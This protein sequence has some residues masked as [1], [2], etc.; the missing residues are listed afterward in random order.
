MFICNY[1]LRGKN[2]AEIQSL[3]YRKEIMVKRDCID[4]GRK[5]VSGH[6]KESDSAFLFV[7]LLTSLKLHV[8]LFPLCPTTEQSDKKAHMLP[9]LVLVRVSSHTSPFPYGNFP[10]GPTL[11]P[12]KNPSSVLSFLFQIVFRQVL[13]DCPVLSIESRY[14]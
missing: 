9:H 10:P 8:F 4:L 1:N 5:L 7:C 14:M 11:Q 2:S 3:G 13:K 12:S 6:N